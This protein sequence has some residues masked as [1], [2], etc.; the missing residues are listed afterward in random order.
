M[1]QWL[2]A[3]PHAQVAHG[4][5]GCMVSIERPGRPAAAPAG[6]G[7]GARHRRAPA[8]ADLHPARAARLGRAGAVRRDHRDAAVRR[9]VH[10][11]RA[12]A[13]RWCTTR[14]W[15]APRSRPRTCSAPPASP[16]RPRRPCARSPTWR[17]RTLALMHGPSF[18]RRLRGGAARPRRRVR[19]AAGPGRRAAGCEM[20]A[21]EPAPRSRTSRRSAAPRPTPLAAGRVR[22]V[23]RAAARAPAAT[24]GT[25]APTAPAGRSR[26]SPHTS[27]ARP[28]RSR[29]R[30]SSS[31]SGGS[32][33][34]VRREIGAHELID[35][36]NEVQVRERRRVA[37]GAGRADDAAAPRAPPHRGRGCPRAAAGRAGRRSAA[38]RPP[39]RRLPRRP[40]DHARRVDAPGGHR[41]RTGR[42]PRPDRRARRP[43]GRRHGRRLG[44]P[45]TSTRSSW[46]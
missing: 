22:A 23:P 41:P 3:A 40:R 8:A 42:G 26:T 29:R 2:A 27:S 14:T 46:S 31:T 33:P 1:N 37:G 7:R 30:G 34:R 13:R 20:A 43:D 28:R 10:P 17:P 24:T 32:A 18:S 45:R 35:G 5:L 6:R 4:A 25:A 21:D 16:R 38:G 15:S 44:R 39:L 12:A 36:V 9:P 19:R 11:G